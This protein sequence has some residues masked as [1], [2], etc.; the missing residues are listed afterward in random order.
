MDFLELV[1]QRYSCRAYKGDPI[2][3]EKLNRILDAMRFAPSACNRQPYRLFV[4][5]TSRFR[6]KLEGVY[7]QPWFVEAPI[8]VAMV[9]FLNEAWCHRD[10]KNLG[11]VDAAI[12][13]DHLL[14]AATHEGY[15]TCWVAAFHRLKAYELLN[16]PETADIL[17]FSPIGVPADRAP[18][19][20]RKSTSEL[21][22]FGVR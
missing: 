2:E 21:V 12:A 7:H 15:G 8:V 19:K 17:A 11:L 5:E 4:L 1:K 22:T 10:G 20:V 9:A 6:S 13:F 14:L 16:L 18:V 3:D